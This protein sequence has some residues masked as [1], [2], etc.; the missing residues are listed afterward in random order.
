MTLPRSPITL[1]SNRADAVIALLLVAAGF[2]IGA[3]YFRTVIAAGGQPWFYQVDFG[4]AV[5]MACGHGFAVPDDTQIPPLGDFLQ[6]K[7]D[8]FSCADL[9]ERPP[10]RAA[11]G[12]QPWLAWAHLIRSAGVVWR[13]TEISWIALA[14]I[15]G[16]FLASTAVLSFMLL[17]LVAGVPLALA[18]TL[19]ILTSPLMLTQLPYFRDFSKVPF[20][21]AIG[22]VFARLM[23]PPVSSR[24]LIALAAVYGAVLGIGLGFRNDPL[25]T[26]PVFVALVAA[27]G[28]SNGGTRSKAAGVAVAMVVAMIAASPVLRVF[29]QGGGAFISHAA[30]LGL[31]KPVDRELG[32]APGTPYEV[33]YGV[34]DTYGAALASAFATRESGAPATVLG[35]SAA[36]DAASSGYLRAVLRTLPADSVIRAYAA[37]LRIVSLPSAPVNLKPPDHVQSPL[38][39]RFFSIRSRVATALR[40][41]WL[42][43]LVVA[44]VLV[45]ARDLRAAVILTVLGFYFTTYSVIQFHQR[46]I[47][48]LELI[49]IAAMVFV[50][51]TIVMRDWRGSLSHAILFLLAVLAALAVP[52]LAARWYQQRALT[53]LFNAYLAAPTTPLALQPALLAD[54]RVQLTRAD[55]E[56]REWSRAHP[57]AVLTEYVVAELGACAA[58][59]VTMALRYDGTAD[60][61]SFERDYQVAA[62][63]PGQTTRVMIATFAYHNSAAD[64]WYHWRGFDLPAD[65]APC[66]QRVSKMTSPERF[67]V[68]LNV[69]LAPGWDQRPLY[70]RL[71]APP[72]D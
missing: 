56:G 60:R 37:G 39:L 66:L 26:L 62:P 7:V 57:D 16:V 11:G 53:G 67:P 32:I 52:M 14:P 21:L 54:G 47:M 23:P 49:A 44:L 33:G 30:L 29:S 48:H 65:Q 55:G 69:T 50:L 64:I 35:H 70:A 51:Q 15:A 10:L 17:R 41:V 34:T 4:P 28:V 13:F 43:V 27:A 20:M 5:M 59:V 58:P 31:M 42:P 18:G 2:T 12:A 19:A 72:A 46:H 9:P 24:R 63:P 36:Y 6:R 22:W 8:R 25:V 40:W 3:G 71:G 61:E 38:A 68:L 1:G 45:A